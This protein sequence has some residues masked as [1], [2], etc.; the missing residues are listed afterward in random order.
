M[1]NSNR[2][3]GCRMEQKGV[4]EQHLTAEK[5]IFLQPFILT[6]LVLAKESTKRLLK[7]RSIVNY[8]L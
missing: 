1:K 4:Q 8:L 3:D 5:N 6:A 2:E 7:Q